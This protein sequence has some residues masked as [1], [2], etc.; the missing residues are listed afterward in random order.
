VRISPAN[1]DAGDSLFAHGVAE[2]RGKKNANK[3]MAPAGDCGS[4]F[5]FGGL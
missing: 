4:G 5:E 2:K 1:V 3:T